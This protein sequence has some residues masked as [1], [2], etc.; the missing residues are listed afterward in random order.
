MEIERSTFSKCATQ[1]VKYIEPEEIYKAVVLIQRIY[2]VVAIK[3]YVP[4]G[5]M[6]ILPVYCT[7]GIKY[8]F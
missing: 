2:V 1:H 3:T 8:H 4:L 7:T 5:F 6:G